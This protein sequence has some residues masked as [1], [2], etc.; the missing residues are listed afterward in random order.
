MRPFLLVQSW[1]ELEERKF[2]GEVG[3]KIDNLDMR[4]LRQLNQLYAEVK[5]VEGE[6]REGGGRRY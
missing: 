1:F 5:R 2:V 6:V 3:L 4:N